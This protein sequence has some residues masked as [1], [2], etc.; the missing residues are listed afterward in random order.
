MP[1]SRLRRKMLLLK[2]AVFG[3]PLLGILVGLRLA[4]PGLKEQYDLTRF[5][6]DAV[7]LQRTHFRLYTHH[8][9]TYGHQ[10]AD[11][12]E[13]FFVAFLEAYGQEFHLA[14]GDETSL[15]YAFSSQEELEK[16]SKREFH[17]PMVNNGG[18]YSPGKREIGIV[19]RGE[20]LAQ[21]L[22]S[23]YHEAVHM[24]FDIGLGTSVESSLS[25]WLNEG[26]AVYF[27]DG[28][29]RSNGSFSWGSCSPHEVRRL[30]ILVGD[31]LEA[32]ASKP[33]LR[34]VVGADMK[35]FTGDDNTFFYGASYL[36][37][38][39]L[40]HG[41]DGAHRKRLFDYYELESERGPQ[42]SRPEVFHRAIGLDPEELERRWRRHVRQ[43]GR[44]LARG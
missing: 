20:D 28:V 12:I 39:F 3:V 24:A 30:V 31:A 10:L 32:N 41:E 4:L 33:V 15:V 1:A 43:L 27:G 8:E 7:E 2:G 22:S 34:S 36:L 26:L 25:P 5:S 16:W 42:G 44:E 17:D 23:A 37:V 35:K 21:D 13:A 40:M 6:S 14:I 18:F 9:P 11:G 19:A 29:V 38:H